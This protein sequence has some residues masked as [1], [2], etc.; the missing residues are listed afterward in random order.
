VLFV[1]GIEGWAE[2]WLP[3]LPAFSRYRW[4]L[5]DLPGFGRS[6]PPAVINRTGMLHDL[7]RLLDA[8]RVDRTLVVGNSL[9]GGLALALAV[10]RPQRV[11]R[12]IVATAAGILRQLA[13]TFKIA[14][15]PLLGELLLAT[16]RPM[17]KLR[18]RLQFGSSQLFTP[19]FLD[20]VSRFESRHDCRRTYLRLLRGSVNL[21]GLTDVVTEQL[22]GLE[23]PVLMAWGSRDRVIPVSHGVFAAKA[24]PNARLEVFHGCGHYPH[25]EQP[26]RF[27]RLVREFLEAP[28]SAVCA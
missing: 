1:H 16:R 14:M 23:Q 20:E 12:I 13:F 19:E 11:E 5:P 18:W 7:H 8:E 6:S 4:L 10:D 22:P 28:V 24:L 27:N 21:F 3:N 17:V 26:E 9:G 15:L 2:Q 25:W